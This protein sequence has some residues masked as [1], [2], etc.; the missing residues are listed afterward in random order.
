M[1]GSVHEYQEKGLVSKN[2]RLLKRM[3]LDENDIVVALIV[4]TEH[5]KEEGI[6][7]YFRRTRNGVELAGF[8]D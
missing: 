7:F 4:S 2:D 3:R 1:S 5:L 6:G 8:W